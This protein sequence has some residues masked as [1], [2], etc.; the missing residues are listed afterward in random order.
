MSSASTARPRRC[1]DQSD[2]RSRSA[3]CVG[4]FG[5]MSTER[6]TQQQVKEATAEAADS[7]PPQNVP[8]NVYETP[9]AVVVLA[10]M[11]AVTGDDVTI[12]LTPGSLRFCAEL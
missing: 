1:R 4:R 9:G 3:G 10:P 8:V 12:E 11:P 5:G 7:R 6:P 2:V